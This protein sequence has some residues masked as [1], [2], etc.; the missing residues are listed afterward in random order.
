MAH[1]VNQLRRSVGYRARRLVGFRRT[2]S[3]TASK[4]EIRRIPSLCSSGLPL[5]DNRHQLL[6]CCQM[7]LR[8]QFFWPEFIDWRD[9]NAAAKKLAE[10]C[11]IAKS[12]HLY[13]LLK[14]KYQLEL[15][16]Q[17]RVPAGI[18]PKINSSGTTCVIGGYMKKTIIAAGI[19][20]MITTAAAAETIGVSMA[21]F[22]DNFLTVLRNGMIS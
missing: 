18:G 8:K 20:S 19:A 7:L 21:R 3:W 13:K 14:L 1:L 17:R 4:F 5:V 22:D 6:A 15:L 9:C 11:N 2:E 16:V 10:R 12:A